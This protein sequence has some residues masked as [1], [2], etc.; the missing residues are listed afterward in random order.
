VPIMKEH[1]LVAIASF[2]DTEA[3]SVASG[4]GLVRLY[5]D[6]ALGDQSKELIP[7]LGMFVLLFRHVT[8]TDS[9]IEAWNPDNQDMKSK[10][11]WSRLH[12]ILHPILACRSARTSTSRT[13]ARGSPRP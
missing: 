13:C 6:V 11:V 7:G 2:A 3:D 1:G 8:A 4:A 5:L 9:A 12:H 10:V